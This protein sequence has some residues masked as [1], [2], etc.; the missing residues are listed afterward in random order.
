[1]SLIYKIAN[2]LEWSD[3]KANGQF[4]GSKDD[5]R[6]GFI[7]FSTADQVQDTL[8]KH[9]KDQRDLLL[10]AVE[11]AKLGDALKWEPSR[12]GALFPHLYAPLPTTVIMWEKPI[13]VGKAGELSAPL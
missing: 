10:I 12:G 7:H 3:A 13:P 1:M 9:F 6:D 11:T 2:Q 4:E 8:D 5:L